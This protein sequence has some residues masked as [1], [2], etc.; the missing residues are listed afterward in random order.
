MSFSAARAVHFA[1]RS[2]SLDRC[3][4]HPGLGM[5]ACAG[6]DDG[7][8]RARGHSA[9]RLAVSCRPDSTTGQRRSALLTRG[10]LAGVS[11][12]ITR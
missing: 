10:G 7:I 12:Q 2:V 3:L 5:N 9:L 11:R 6:N 1:A 8:E 4:D